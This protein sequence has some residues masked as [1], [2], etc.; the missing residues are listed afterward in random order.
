MSVDRNI[1]YLEGDAALPRKNGELVFDAP[2][3][4]RAFGLAVVLNEKGSYGWDDFRRRLVHEIAAG[5]RGYYESWLDAL[6][7]LVTSSGLVTAEEVAARA[8][9]YATLER[10]PVF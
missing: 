8:R 9:E 5:E 10:D 6:E 1:A 7:G 2:W 3:Q 4:G